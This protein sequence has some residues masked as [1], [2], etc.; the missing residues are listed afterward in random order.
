M[1][2]SPF[3]LVM[4]ELKFG[5]KLCRETA[6]MEPAIENCNP[7]ALY[8]GTATAVNF[9]LQVPVQGPGQPFRSNNP[10]D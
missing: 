3:I 1:P 2:F 4:E 8:V 7:G 6:S 10:F 5:G 9:G